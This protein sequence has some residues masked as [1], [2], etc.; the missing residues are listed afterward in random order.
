VLL[1]VEH[2]ASDVADAGVTQPTQVRIDRTDREDATSRRS[3]RFVGLCHIGPEITE[4]IVAEDLC[5]CR[6]SFCGRRPVTEAVDDQGGQRL[7]ESDG[8][9]VARL[10][11]IAEGEVETSVSAAISRSPLWSLSQLP[12]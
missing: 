7:I 3:H 2:P 12:T 6:R 9:A 8:E 5:R 4:R 11:G 1:A 10:G